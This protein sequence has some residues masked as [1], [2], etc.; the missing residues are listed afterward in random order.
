MAKSKNN[1]AAREE[2]IEKDREEVQLETPLD[3]VEEQIDTVSAEE[4]KSLTDQHLR[5]LAE[6]DNYR[7]RTNKEKESLY[8]EALAEIAKEF[9]PV[10]D[11]IE[12]AIYHSQNISDTTASKV[13]E[14]IDMIYR[15]VQ[16]VFDKL[17]IEP[18]DCDEGSAFDPELHEAVMHVEDEEFGEQCIV[19]VFQKGYK[20]KDKI[21]RHTVVKVAN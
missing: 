15:Q 6:Y 14:G 4:F 3:E 16:D 21:I 20:A 12:R 7:K 13:A 11:N 10:V 18:I 5:L 19:Q 8:A 17:G 1:K 9:L 2:E